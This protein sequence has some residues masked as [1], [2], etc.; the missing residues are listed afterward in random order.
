MKK[1]PLIGVS[2][3]AVIVLILGSLNNVVGFQTVQS[4][5]QRIINDKVNQK[6]LLFQTIVDIA[7]NKEIQQ[8]ILKLQIN[9]DGLFKMDSKFSL[10][11][12]PVLT[13][14][15][16]KHMYLIGL[17][18]SKV[19]SKSKIRSVVEQY[20]MNN[21]EVQKEISAVI[22]KDAILKGEMTQLSDVKC[23][24]ENND[25][26]RLWNFP[27]ICLL[28]LPIAILAI[29]LYIGIPHSSFL[30]EIIGPIGLALNCFWAH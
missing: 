5:N 16:L 17:M 11:N 14:N 27:I 29:A 4:S 9:R 23:D 15:Q 25:E 30:L 6:E 2:I 10:V 8:I 28:L 22:E 26:T 20:Q 19:I 3:V 21:Q 24:C 1:Y 18:L 7:N 12:T 13:K